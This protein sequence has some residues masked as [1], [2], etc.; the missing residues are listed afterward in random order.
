MAE[1]ARSRGLLWLVVRRVGVAVALALVISFLVYAATTVLP[2]DVAAAVLGRNASPEAVAALREQLGLDQPFLQRYVGWL[3]D[4]L[5]G[6][7]GTSLAGTRMPV[8]ELIATPARNTIVLAGATLLILIPL[9]LV[10]GV[11]SGVRQGRGLDRAAAGVSLT[12][13]AV[14]EF[15]VGALLVIAFA[16][17]LPV[18]PAVSLV[19]GDVHPLS[20]PEFLVLPVVTLVIAGA[21]YLIR[22]V[23]VSTIE[24]MTTDYVEAARL[25]GVP[26]RRV[27]LRYAVRNS[28]A[29]TI[30]AVAATAQWLLGGVFVVEVLFAYPGIGNALVAAVQVRDIPVIQAVAMLLALAFILINLV[31]DILTILADPRLRTAA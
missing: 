17:Y 29:P 6:D 13:T 3:G 12:L 16:V 23:R 31:A 5:R 2:G 25:A 27:V 30:Q 9:A 22:I 11:L 28:L 8:A 26:E 20:V 1:A 24:A 21:A 10:I 15:V 14:P 19:S 4:L 7:L 18:L